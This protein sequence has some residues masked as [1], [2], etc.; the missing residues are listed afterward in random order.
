MPLPRIQPSCRGWANDC[1]ARM[2]RKS[3]RAMARVL[4]HGRVIEASHKLRPAMDGPLDRSC[5]RPTRTCSHSVLVSL[6][7]RD[8]L[9]RVAA[10]YPDA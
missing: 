7:G 4:A 8:R 3:N 5:E 9:Q 1:I 10:Q 6:E 2:M